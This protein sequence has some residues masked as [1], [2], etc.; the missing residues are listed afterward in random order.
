M[1]AFN[2]VLHP[3][4]NAKEKTFIVAPFSKGREKG[5]LLLRL[6]PF[7]RKRGGNTF[8]ALEIIWQQGQDNEG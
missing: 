3:Q 5:G 8:M 4:M 7:A 1:D 6:W 2:F